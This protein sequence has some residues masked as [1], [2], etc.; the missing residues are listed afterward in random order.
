[1]AG[2]L[3]LD[4]RALGRK[5]ACACRVEFP[6]WAWYRAHGQQRPKPDLR[7]RDFL[8]P[9]QQGVRIELDLPDEQVPLSSFDGWPAVL[10]NW[11]LL[12]A[13][14]NTNAPSA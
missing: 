8:E 7:K 2:P 3:P 10:N 1:M 14:R 13:T 6:V 11:F 12:W 5:N 4:D 9:G